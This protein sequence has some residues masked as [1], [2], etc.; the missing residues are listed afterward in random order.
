MEK[1]KNLFQ[2]AGVS[3]TLADS[4]IEEI[5]NHT[6]AVKESYEKQ[7]SDKLEK[8]RQVCLEQLNKEKSRLSKKVAIYLESKK[9]QIS[10]A[11]EKQ[12]LNEDTEA[13]SLL[14]RTRAILEGIQMD[15]KGQNQDLQAA[16]QQV[17]RLQKAVTTIKEERDLAVKKANEAN[18]IALENL[19]KN[20][21]L[22]NKIQT[23]Q[24]TIQ[25]SKKPET[26]VAQENKEPVQR[27]RLDSNRKVPVK[28]QSTRPVLEENQ[29]NRTSGKKV[30]GAAAT[31][32]IAGIAASIEEE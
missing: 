27:Q 1:L 28:S 14:K 15:D 12:R 23:E 22:E 32:D 8:A 5:G 25:E 24:K 4:I 7:F 21:L 17:T 29:T 13:T 2:Q 18:R 16:R 31:G 9:E 3:E 11:A 20:R 19:R 30:T 26:N 10:R 6:K